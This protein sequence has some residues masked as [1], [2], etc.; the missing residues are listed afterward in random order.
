V[1]EYGAAYYTSESG[2]VRALLPAGTAAD[3]DRLRAALTGVAGVQLDGDYRYS[4]RAFRV[5]NGR[6]VGLDAD[7]T[8]T[9][10]A[11]AA[12]Q[13]LRPIPGDGQ[14]DFVVAGIDK[15]TGLRALMAELGA[16]GERP[17]ALAVGDTASDLPLAG[18]ANRACAPRHADK[19]LERNGFEAMKRPYQ[20]G[21]AQAVRD[22]IGHAPGS[23]DVCRAPRATPQR[24]IL[25]GML[26]VGERGPAGIALQALELSWRLR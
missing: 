16:E 20:A 15:G 23:C 7:T 19:V 14:T 26:A 22:L 17:L 9:A 24:N 4:V 11:R 25:L 2:S 8:N 1:A 3:L 10:L 21:T 12:V 5:V 6:R 13:G 18:L